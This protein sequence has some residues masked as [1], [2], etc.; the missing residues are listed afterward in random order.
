MVIPADSYVTVVTD[1]AELA[2]ALSS[3]S[4]ESFTFQ[5]ILYAV[6]A[7]LIFL[8][9]R[10]PQKG[11]HCRKMLFRDGHDPVSAFC[12]Y[13][14]RGNKRAF[15]GPRLIFFL[16]FYKH[17]R[18]ILREVAL[19]SLAGAIALKIYPVV[20][21][22]LLIADRKIQEFFRECIYIFV[23]LILPFFYFL[24]PTASG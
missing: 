2:G 24:A 15:A 7:L 11:R 13:G 17:D 8:A 10:V 5:F 20:C 23:F 22:V 19:I 1:P 6:I 12:L 14:G 9:A 21:L 18:K 3:T 4:V 16:V